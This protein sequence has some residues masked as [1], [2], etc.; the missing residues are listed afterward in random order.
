MNLK[1]L[2][3]YYYFIR[4]YVFRQVLKHIFTRYLKTCL[5]YA[6]A[7]VRATEKNNPFFTFLN[8]D[9]F[10]KNTENSLKNQVFI[11]VICI[12]VHCQFTF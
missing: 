4:L 11:I 10:L 7:K 5:K 6:F 8:A 2:Y 1:M 3:R 12:C 9:Y